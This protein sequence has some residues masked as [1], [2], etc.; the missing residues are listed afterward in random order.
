MP[1]AIA[2]GPN[3]ITALCLGAAFACVACGATDPSALQD[4]ALESQDAGADAAAPATD[5][6]VP[7]EDPSEFLAACSR[8]TNA[9]FCVRLSKNCGSVTARDNCGVR[10]TVNCGR[11]TTPQTCGGGGTANVCGCTPLPAATACAGKNCGIAANGCGGTV[12]CGACVA[13]QTCGGGGTANVC[14]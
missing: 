11:C 3:L 2:N 10:R 7:P 5:P 1:F 12:S 6:T 13:P 4:K 14:G 8:E 9:A